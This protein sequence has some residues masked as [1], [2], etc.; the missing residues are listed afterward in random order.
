[1]DK[2]V[3]ELY[4]IFK[5]RLIWK[6]ELLKNIALMN[7]ISRYSDIPGLVIDESKIPREIRSLLPLAVKWNITD[8]LELEAYIHAAPEHERRH[9]VESFAPHLDSIAAWVEQS[10]HL[11]PLPDEVAVFDVAASVALRV[12]RM[13][14]VFEINS[15]QPSRINFGQEIG[16]V[17][18]S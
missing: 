18:A 17:V 12:S 9:F 4:L 11:M 13:P 1:M 3:L 16:F 14:V 6:L 8:Y 2:R 10:A 5:T 7:I 15:R